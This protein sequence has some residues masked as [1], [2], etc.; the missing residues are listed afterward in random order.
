MKT[1]TLT[2][3]GQQ[4]DELAQRFYT[5]VVDGGLEDQIIDTLS[6]PEVRVSG[7]VDLDTERLAIAIGSQ[8]GPAA[9]G[10]TDR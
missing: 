9:G 3:V 10:D 6:T 4:S 8:P 1:V 7:V 2:F 5:W